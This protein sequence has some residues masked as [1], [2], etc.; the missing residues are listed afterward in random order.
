MKIRAAQNPAAAATILP[1]ITPTAVGSPTVMTTQK[2]LLTLDD[3]MSNGT[4]LGQPPLKRHAMES[5]II[6][7]SASLGTSPTLAASATPTANPA[8]ATLYGY[9][10]LCSVPQAMHST[11]TAY[12]QQAVP[13][14][15]LYGG[16]IGGAITTPVTTPSAQLTA[17]NLPNTSS[18]A[19]ANGTAASYAF[20]N[21]QNQ[22]ML[23]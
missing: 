10:T 4:A 21:G 14:L 2:R 19:A 11:P 9:N 22:I 16:G 6:T 5:S 7:S 1:P 23:K 18:N 15:Q 17:F 8:L 12:Y 13:M 3:V 20:L